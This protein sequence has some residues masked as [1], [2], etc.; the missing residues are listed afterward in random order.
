[1]F[2][3]VPMVEPDNPM[4]ARIASWLNDSKLRRHDDYV[5][6]G[7]CYAQLPDELLL[8]SWAL[9]RQCSHIRPSDTGLMHEQADLTSEIELRGLAI[10]VTPAYDAYL[11]LLDCEV[12]VPE[13]TP[14]SPDPFG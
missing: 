11:A 14:F 13:D 8:R 5:G 6:R 3:G 4:Q 1:M 9:S 10:P 2:P 12:R 7:R